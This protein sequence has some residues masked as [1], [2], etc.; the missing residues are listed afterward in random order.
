[1]TAA[2]PPL[3]GLR[4]VV[5]LAPGAP[6]LGEAIAGALTAG[7]ATIRSHDAGGRRATSAVAALEAAAAAQGGLDVVVHVAAPSRPRPF[8][9]RDDATW[10]ADLAARIG[11]PVRI[12]RAAARLMRGAGG[13]IVFVGTL[14][15]SHAY[16]GHADASVAMGALLGLVRTL[17]VE[18]A[19]QR[20]RANAVLAGPLTPGDPAAAADPGGLARTLLRSPAG[21]F[22][23]P[24][25]VA[26]AV[27]FAAGPGAAFM[28]GATLRVDGGW[29]ALNQAPDGMRF[30]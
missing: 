10:T 16:A 26:A 24:R 2:D 18:L 30:A 5:L 11:E 25:E 1:M 6:P 9:D 27:A 12:A 23:T 4:A 19:P 21:R 14:D 20:V 17:A 22:V 3:A 28:T 13:A 15:A 7:G 8:L 29:A